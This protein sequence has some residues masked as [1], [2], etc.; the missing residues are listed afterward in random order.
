[1]T[2]EMFRYVFLGGLAASVVCAVIALVLFFTLHIPKVMSDLSGRTERKAIENIRRQNEQSGTKRHGP[3]TENLKRGKIT[4]KLTE[5]GK[6]V[7][8][9]GISAGLSSTTERLNGQ[10]MEDGSGETSVLDEQNGTTVLSQPVGETSVL[11]PQE[12]QG[13][14]VEFEITF[15]HSNEVIT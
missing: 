5:S 1:M 6:L 2:Y 12:E 15:I 10:Y 13:F 3:S 9:D 7:K 14:V 11:E 4:D 8:N